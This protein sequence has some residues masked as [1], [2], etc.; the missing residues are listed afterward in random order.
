MFSSE[1]ILIP[2]DKFSSVINLFMDYL[3]EYIIE[4]WK[5]L[6]GYVTVELIFIYLFL[7]TA[8]FCWDFLDYFS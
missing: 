3:L 2:I 5:E 7:A 8:V 4:Y 1:T 6:Y